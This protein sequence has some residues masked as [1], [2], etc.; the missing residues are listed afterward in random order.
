[1]SWTTLETHPEIPPGQ[2]VVALYY[3]QLPAK[4]TQLTSQ[5]NATLETKIRWADKAGE[6]KEEILRSNI[7][8]RGVDEIARVINIGFAASHDGRSKNLA[9]I[10]SSGSKPIDR[11]G[12]SGLKGVRLGPT[13]AGA[14]SLHVAIV[15][16][17]G[18]L[19]A[20]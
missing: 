8:R 1:V 17:N 16:R 18:D 14:S 9:V 7:I 19:A 13:Y 5:T 15:N 2:T 11:A 12:A 4:V 20:I 3:P 6:M 10:S